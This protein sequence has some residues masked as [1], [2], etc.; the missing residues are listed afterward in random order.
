MKASTESTPLLQQAHAG[1]AGAREQVF[2]AVLGGPSI[3]ETARAP[4]VSHTT[5]KSDDGTA[6]PRLRRKVTPAR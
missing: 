2:A 5:V 1:M 3:D 4:D 6:L